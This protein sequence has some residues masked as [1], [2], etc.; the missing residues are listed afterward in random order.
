MKETRLYLFGEFAYY[1]VD[2]QFEKEKAENYLQTW[3]EQLCRKLSKEYTS[4]KIVDEIK[5]HRDAC[6][7]SFLGTVASVAIKVT[8]E[9]EFSF[10]CDDYTG[11]FSIPCMGT[12]T[13]KEE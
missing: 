5:I 12:V 8:V 13:P 7:V 1:P 4:A 3:K 11:A 9:I 2:N 6:L 10:K